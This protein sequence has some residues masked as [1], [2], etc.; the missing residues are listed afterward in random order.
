LVIAVLDAPPSPHLVGRQLRCL[1]GVLVADGGDR[2]DAGRVL[3][4]EVGNPAVT[5]R[6][7][8]ADLAVP[9]AQTSGP[10]P[11]VALGHGLAHDRP[12]P[13]AEPPPDP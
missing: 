3:E 2:R 9:G 13:Y 10:P 12:R 11:S 4:A 5:A 6:N 8:A 1:D 7:G